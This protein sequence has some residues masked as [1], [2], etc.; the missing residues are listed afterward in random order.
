MRIVTAD[1]MREIDRRTI[2]DI[3]IPSL[4]LM[5]RAGEAV[6][7]IIE[8]NLDKSRVVVLSGGGNNGM[9]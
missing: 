4:V 5:E 9:G 3:G 6:A 2:H 1:Q 7:D 8:N